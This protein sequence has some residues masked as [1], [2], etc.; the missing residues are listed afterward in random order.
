M[1]HQ[2]EGLGEP[3]SD[4]EMKDMLA[5]HRV[6]VS[7][8]VPM[9][10]LDTAQQN[11]IDAITAVEKQ[12]FDMVE[13]LRPVLRPPNPEDEL[14]SSKVLEEASLPVAPHTEFLQVQTARLNRLAVQI[15]NG[16]DRLA[17]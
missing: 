5:S 17:V 4:R 11:L 14:T 2:H 6:G 1:Q 9:S 13:Q 7:P 3:L 15:E 10:E 16:A 12:V 8:A